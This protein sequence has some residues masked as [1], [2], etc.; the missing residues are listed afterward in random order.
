M[1]IF[2]A[3]AGDHHVVVACSDTQWLTST[4]RS[5]DFR[6]FL[7]IK[8]ISLHTFRFSFHD[9]TYNTTHCVIFLAVANRK[10]DSSLSIT[11]LRNLVYR[12]VCRAEYKFSETDPCPV[13]ESD[14]SNRQS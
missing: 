14:P 11:K 6:Y 8:V 9:Y 10:Q 4:L 2:H 3:T 1:F 5:S 7:V 13:I 12:L